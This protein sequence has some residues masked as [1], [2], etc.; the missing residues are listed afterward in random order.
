[1]RNPFRDP[2]MR[3]VFADDVAAFKRRTSALFTADGRRNTNHS[4]GIDFWLGFDNIGPEA[5]DAASRRQL[6]YASYRAG[7]YCAKV[8]ALAEVSECLK[9]G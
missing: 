1:M 5:W 2:W 3:A 8:D 4:R 7:Q 9:H 6:G